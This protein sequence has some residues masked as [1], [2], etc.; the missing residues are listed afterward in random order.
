MSFS[1]LLIFYT[2]LRDLESDNYLEEEV[3]LDAGDDDYQEMV[4]EDGKYLH[5]TF[6]RQRVLLTSTHA[7]YRRRDTRKTSQAEAIISK[8]ITAAF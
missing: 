6:F 8:R 4:L 7:K 1:C 5:L 2:S 3:Q